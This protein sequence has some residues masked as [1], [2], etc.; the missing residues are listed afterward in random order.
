MRVI[1]MATKNFSN[2]IILAYGAYLFDKVRSVPG[3]ASM[4][5]TEKEKIFISDV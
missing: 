3:A 2:S 1:F 5:K 4:A